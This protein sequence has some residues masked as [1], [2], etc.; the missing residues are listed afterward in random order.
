MCRKS[1]MRGYCIVFFGIGLIIGQC[2]ENWFLCC[3]GGIGLI[4][5]G[6]CVMHQK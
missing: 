3:F 5:L 4:L 2:L 6:F 1:R